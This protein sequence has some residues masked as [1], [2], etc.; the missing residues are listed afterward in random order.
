MGHKYNTY[1]LPCGCAVEFIE[2]GWFELPKARWVISCNLHAAAE[3]ML[4]A[5]KTALFQ[6][7]ILSNVST[8][9]ETTKDVLRAAIA[10]AEPEVE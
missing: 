1:P 5:C 3:Q 10:A 6:L 4:A 2:G 7:R 8:S 9:A